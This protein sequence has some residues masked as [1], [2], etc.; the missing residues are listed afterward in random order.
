[1]LCWL[2]LKAVSLVVVSVLSASVGATAFGPL[3]HSEEHGGLPAFVPH[4]AAAHTF[5]AATSDTPSHPLH[6]LVCQ[7]TRSYRSHPGSVSH[8]AP[9]VEYSL[10]VHAV[11]LLAPLAAIAAQPPLR[12]PPAYV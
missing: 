6:C 10:R 8:L 3:S 7:W 2:R 12:S 5:Q 4:D 1:M 11:P 9:T